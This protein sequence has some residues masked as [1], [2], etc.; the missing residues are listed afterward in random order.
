MQSN[1]RPAMDGG[2]AFQFLFRTRTPATPPPH[3]LDLATPRMKHFYALSLI[4]LITVGSCTPTRQTGESEAVDGLYVESSKSSTGL[5]LRVPHPTDGRIFTIPVEPFDGFVPARIE[6][7]D[8]PEGSCVQVDGRATVDG[9][10]KQPIFLVANRKPYV[11]LSKSGEAV[12]G[13]GVPVG[14]S[15]T[16]SLTVRTR[17]EA[18]AVAA[19][20]RQRFSI[21][22]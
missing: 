1:K 7:F 11:E 12:S 13:T 4:T 9:W 22:P 2:K 18:D 17:V 20:L 6:V 8:T 21:S 5:V 16:I 19:A 15:A 10:S 3:S 14:P